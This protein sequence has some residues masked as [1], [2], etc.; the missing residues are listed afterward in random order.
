MPLK[1]WLAALIVVTAWGANFVVIKIALGEVPPLL[2]GALRFSV[3]AFPAI[4][5][6]KR[7]RVAW[8]TIILYG[9]TISLGQF[10]FLFTAMATGMPAGLASLVLQSQAFFTVLI[11]A[12]VLGEHIRSHNV[13]GMVVAIVGMFLIAQGAPPGTVPLLAFFLTLVAA[14]SWATGNIVAKGAGKQDMLGLVVWGALIPPLPFLAL[15]S[16]IEGPALIHSSLANMTYV[17]LSAVIYLALV[18]TIIG[19]VLWG[20]L[21]VR[22]PV[23]QVAPLSLLVPI[24]GLVSSAWLLDERMALVQWI[25]GAVVMLGLTVNVFGPRLMRMP[26]GAKRLLR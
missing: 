20:R 5:F 24:I 19:Y 6:I 9:L 2:L 4:L 3:V 14:L 18:A 17:G 8:R 10:V 1:D 22:H 23:S 15:S 11:A 7:P 26:P 13:L 21:L 25:G 16:M 12:M